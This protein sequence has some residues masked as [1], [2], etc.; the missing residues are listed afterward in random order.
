MSPAVK[1]TRDFRRGRQGFTY[2]SE[3]HTSELQSP[4][5]LVCRL[6]LEKKKKGST[7]QRGRR[8]LIEPARL[9]ICNNGEGLALIDPDQCRNCQQRNLS[10]SRFFFFF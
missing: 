6:L 9:R 7:E 8:E 5:Y 10:H 3:E 4:M 1:F 2:R